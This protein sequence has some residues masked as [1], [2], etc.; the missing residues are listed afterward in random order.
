VINN[1][2]VRIIHID[3][4]EMG[5]GCEMDLDGRARHRTRPDRRRLRLRIVDRFR[6]IRRMRVQQIIDDEPV[7]RNQSAFGEGRKE[8]TQM[9]RAVV[10][11][12][13]NETKK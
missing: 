13:T 7:I 1:A 12:K 6:I 8:G 10:E 3:V 5:T 9:D 4:W 2:R 11:P